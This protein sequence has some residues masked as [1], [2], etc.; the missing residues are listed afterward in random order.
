MSS[1]WDRRSLALVQVAVLSSSILLM[2]PGAWGNSVTVVEFAQLPAGL[3][4]WQRHSL[5][6]YRV[7]GPVSKFLYAL[8][9]YVAGIRVD[10][11]LSHDSDVQSRQEWD[12]GQ[13]FQK[14][15][16]WR[17]HT[18]Y[19]W[20]RLLPM[21]VTLLG[22]CLICEWS[23]R[24]FGRWPG[25]VSLCVWCWMPPIL[26]HG[27]LVTSDIVSAV[28]IVLAARCFWSMLLAPSP[29]TAI[30]AGA[31][32]GLAAAT[33]FTLLIL[34]PCWALLL[35]GRALQLRGEAAAKPPKKFSPAR[36][37]ACGLGLLMTSIVV[38]DAL[39]L[40]QDVGFHLAQW[41]PGLSSLAKDLHGLGEHRATAWILQVPLPIPL[42]FLRGLDF[43]LADTELVQFTYLLGQTRLGGWWFWYPVA[44]LLKISLPAIALTTI[45]LIRLPRLLRHPSPVVWA[46]LCILLPSVEV[47]V[48]IS[49]TTGTGTN[50]AFR[51]LTPSLGLL[52]VLSGLAWDTRSKN[53]RFAAIG[54]L[55]WMAINAIAGIPGHLGWRNE[56]GWL[57]SRARPAL[58]GDSLD[59]GQDAARLA[60]WIS[61]HS[62]EGSTLVCIYGLGE[63]EP[64]G[65]MAPHALPISRRSSA[66]EFV[67]VS[68]DIL[69]GYEVERTVS[70]NGMR[71]RI[72]DERKRAELQRRHPIDWAG[73]T[74]RI[75]RA[76]DVRDLL[77]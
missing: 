3:A 27:S 47:A 16:S 69:F 30:L 72:Y 54:L 57:F 22:G 42:E 33:K 9:A 45:A 32:L 5:G 73:R 62:R 51:Y 49:A 60:K 38:I 64:Y 43:Q 40:F 6:I 58:I 68:E 70:V 74:I 37:I 34:Y 10:Y 8:P 77:E 67:A 76:V 71:S 17:Y 14:Q 2:L 35:L 75:Y 66:Y 29:L 28:M 39:Y 13:I 46:S 23:T 31:A 44:A 36:L 41:Q 11:P 59:W 55:G 12:L 50:A 26:A 4:A 52:C 18:I 1:R 61:R 21:L 20:S 15:N 24:L 7:C 63:G 48:I 53:V 19:R 65:L 56:L 25:I